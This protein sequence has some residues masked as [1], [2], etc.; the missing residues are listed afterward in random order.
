MKYRYCRSR[1]S[2]CLLR[3]SLCELL[4]VCQQFGATLA[5]ADGCRSDTAAV[6]DV[7]P[8][9]ATL[10]QNEKLVFDVSAAN[11]AQFHGYFAKRSPVRSVEGLLCT[12]IIQS[13]Y[14]RVNLARGVYLPS[15]SLYC[16]KNCYVTKTRVLHSAS[17]FP[18]SC[19]YC[20]NWLIFLSCTGRIWMFRE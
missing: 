2:K 10:L 3:F 11:V 5:T 8:S 15:K 19:F 7:L 13:L 1:I 9:P 12:V 14:L 6:V 20:S 17:F 16:V 18:C 4:I